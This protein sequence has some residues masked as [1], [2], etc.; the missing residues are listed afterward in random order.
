MNSIRYSDM[1]WNQLKP[2]TQ[3]KLHGLLSSGVSTA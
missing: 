1:L 3:T 2:A